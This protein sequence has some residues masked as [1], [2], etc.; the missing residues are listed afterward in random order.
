[1]KMY[2]KDYDKNDF[3][4]MIRDWKAD[5]TPEYDDL[6]IEDP[7]MENGKWVAVASDDAQ[8]YLLTDDGRGNI[9]INYLDTK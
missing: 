6:A 3:L 2:I 8:R 9:Q 4:E 5:G 7:Y 1:M